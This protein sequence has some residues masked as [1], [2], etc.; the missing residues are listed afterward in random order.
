MEWKTWS[1]RAKQD[2]FFREFSEVSCVYLKISDL[3]HVSSTLFEDEYWQGPE[4]AHAWYYGYGGDGAR[5]H[6]GQLTWEW[7]KCIALRGVLHP[8]S[9]P[10][11]T[12]TNQQ[13]YTKPIQNSNQICQRGTLKK[14]NA[15]SD[16]F[17]FGISRVFFKKRKL[18]HW[19]RMTEIGWWLCVA[20]LFLLLLAALPFE[21]PL[22][23]AYAP[24]LLQGTLASLADLAAA[25]GSRIRMRHGSGVLK[26]KAAHWLKQDALKLN[27]Y[28]F[29]SEIDE[30]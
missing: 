18:L 11:Q 10:K 30:L 7:E 17:K 15:E 1:T 5:D 16:S 28:R 20:G 22:L 25:L 4:V 9:M 3:K 19:Q 24:R 14:L 29:G 21:S 26:K 12:E 6:G 8:G 27:G 13:D 2:W 23:V